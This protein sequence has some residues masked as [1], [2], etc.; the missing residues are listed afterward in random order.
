M[1][2]LLLA[3]TALAL[4]GCSTQATPL[5]TSSASPTA[6]LASLRIHYGLPDCPGTDPG[7]VQIDG[8][9][10]QT[11]LPC[12]GSGTPVNLAGLPK[13]PTVVNIWAQWCGPCREESPFL[14]TAL[15]QHPEVQFVGINYNDPK[16]DWALEFASLAGWNYPH[17]QD[18]DKTL[19]TALAVPGVPMTLFVDAEGRITYRHPGVI[20]SQAELA[21]LI[22]EHL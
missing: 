1:R 6:D 15:E 21:E 11:Q 12:L 13:Q 14:R 10:P 17:I 8:G 20:K 22:A 5:P 18:M 16:P 3:V 9:L 19:R 2:R 4:V 7:A